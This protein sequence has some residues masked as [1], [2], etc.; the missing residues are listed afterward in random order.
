MRRGNDENEMR[1]GVGIACSMRHRHHAAI[2]GADADDRAGAEMTA[3]RLHV[4]DILVERIFAGVAAGGTPLAAMVEIDELHALG[5]RG[6]DRLEAAVIA[7]RP[8]MD[9]KGYRA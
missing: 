3:Q 7:A 8:A 4:L 5:E 9:D 1:D 2:G 6:Q